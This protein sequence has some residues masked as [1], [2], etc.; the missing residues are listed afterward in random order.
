[1]L[2]VLIET[3][4]DEDA[5]ARTLASLVPGAVQGVVREVLVHDRGSTDRTTAV[6]DHTGCGIIA[7][8]DLAAALGQARGDWFLILEPGARLSEGWI[9]AV[10]EHAA[11]HTA[12]ARFRRSREAG[13]GFLARLFSRTRPLAHGLLV[14]KSHA[15]SKLRSG[16]ALE[17]FAGRVG[18]RRIDAAIMPPERPRKP[19]N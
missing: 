13:P 17:S 18:G 7:D 10:V 15:L 4:N 6:A 5:L 1:M 2:T 8:G 3:H 19:R 14:S 16:E 11:Q 12:A 9:E